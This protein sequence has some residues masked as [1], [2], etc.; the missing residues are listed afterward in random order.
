MA[1]LEG[2]EHSA[3][4]NIVFVGER[5]PPLHELSLEDALKR[6]GDDMVDD[7][8]SPAMFPRR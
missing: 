3:G 4:E 6:A 5:I 1:F 7:D 2:F 8:L